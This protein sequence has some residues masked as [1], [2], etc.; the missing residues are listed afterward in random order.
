MLPMQALIL[1]DRV[2]VQSVW[3]KGEIKSLTRQ[4]ILRL[5]KYWHYEHNRPVIFRVCIVTRNLSQG[6]FVA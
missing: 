3:L 5:E 6:T 4:S 2:F 1:R